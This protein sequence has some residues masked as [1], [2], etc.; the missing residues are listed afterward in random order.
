MTK[1][2]INNPNDFQRDIKIRGQRLEALEN[3]KC[4]NSNEGSRHEIFSRTAQTTV[5]L[6]RL[7]I[8]RRNKNISLASKVKL[9]RIH[10]Y[11]PSFMSVRSGLL[12]MN[13]KEEFELKCYRRR[14]TK[15]V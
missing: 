10:T 15:T 8:I 3:F 7:K 13:L 5:A 2:M 11:L 4:L 6:S 12:Q 1:V 9:M 14:L